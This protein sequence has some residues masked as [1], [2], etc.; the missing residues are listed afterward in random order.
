MTLKETVFGAMANSGFLELAVPFRV[1]G[2]ELEYL[3]TLFVVLTMM[4]LD[5]KPTELGANVAFMEN[6]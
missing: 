1:T 3:A 2:T 5:S 6:V 4:S